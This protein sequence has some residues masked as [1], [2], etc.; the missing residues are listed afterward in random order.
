M[1]FPR[2]VT[3]A[4]FTSCVFCACLMRISPAV[5]DNVFGGDEG[6]FLLTAGFS[7]LEG[8]G[9]GGLVPL[10][11]ISGYGSRNS[12]G[13]NAHFTNIQ[14]RDF[15]LRAYG[16]TVGALDRVEL[17]YTRQLLDVTGT[18]LDGLGVAQDIVSLKI[19][20]LGDAV[21]SQDAWIPQLAF[22][23]DYQKNEGIS[24]GASVGLPGVV[25]PTQLGARAE[26]GTDYYLAATK[27]FLAQSFVVNAVLRYTRANA[28]G[29]LGFGG[30]RKDS[31]SLRP[32]GTLAYLLTRKFAV[33]AEYRGRPH[34]LS[35]DD[36]TAGWD[37]FAAW[38]PTKNISLVAAYLNVGSILGPVTGVT[39]HQDGPYLSIQAGF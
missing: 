38:A 36:E 6:K 31:Y 27:V 5:A 18:K 35:V 23:V 16:V 30:D 11:L 28:F 34:N 8:A 20:L 29:L 21:Y 19:K 2:A 10:A 12:W 1:T 25:N 15:T 17:S 14:L 39:R 24:D 32:E 3:A 13:A 9:G 33:G 37:V 22:G 4:A 26:H 7:D